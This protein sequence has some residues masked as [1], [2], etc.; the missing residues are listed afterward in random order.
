MKQG[1]NAKSV[2]NLLEPWRC[3]DIKPCTV[4]LPICS[5]KEI[6]KGEESCLVFC[7]HCTEAGSLF[8]RNGTVTK[9]FAWRCLQCCW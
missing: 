7:T 8:L 2:D 9:P 1:C 6:H 4:D 5:P 3:L